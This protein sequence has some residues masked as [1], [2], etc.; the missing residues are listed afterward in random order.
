MFEYSEVDTPHFRIINSGSLEKPIQLHISH[1]T[2]FCQFSPHVQRV[3]DLYWENRVRE[4]AAEGRHLHDSV[5][6]YVRKANFTGKT[7]ALELGNLRYRDFRGFC[8]DDIYTMHATQHMPCY[9]LAGAIVET[10]DGYLM[11]NQRQNVELFDGW[12]NLFTGGIEIENHVNEHGDVSPLITV[13][14]EIHE[15]THI[16]YPKIADLG[17]IGLVRNTY[18]PKP[19]TLLYHVKTSL[20]KDEVVDIQSRQILKEGPTR[21][22]PFTDWHLYDFIHRFRKVMLSESLAMLFLLGKE[23]FGDVWA[24]RILNVLHTPTTLE[25]EHEYVL[26]Q[27]V[28]EYAA[29]C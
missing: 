1:K 2:H 6:P 3:L 13:R 24:S 18:I 25:R 26:I 9:M 5:L 15:E 4:V 20:R 28:R 12:I 23:A 19:Y 8:D 14:E 22:I 17:C 10:A 16:P 11:L 29:V 27:Q 21:F 7:L